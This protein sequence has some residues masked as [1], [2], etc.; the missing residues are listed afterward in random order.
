M[1]KFTIF[2]ICA[3]NLLA[4]SLAAAQEF[5]VPTAY[6]FEN[7]EDYAFYSGDV[8]Q[9]IRWLETTPLN[10]EIEKREL[11]SQFLFQWLSGSPEISIHIHPYIMELSQ[12]NPEYLMV[13]MGGWAKQ[14]IQYEEQ[15]HLKLNLL[16]IHS[17]INLYKLGGIKK[18]VNLENL[19]K[20][21][22]K[23]VLEKW[24]KEKIS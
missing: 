21:Q 11:V 12:E 22:E 18:D 1:K 5:E 13:F 10:K 15:N 20:M 17:V 8:I 19:I 23:G 2:V 7:I 9:A 24:L 14:Q 16:G 3:L 4:V 6:R